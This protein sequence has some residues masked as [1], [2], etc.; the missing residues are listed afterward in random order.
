VDRPKSREEVRQLVRRKLG[1][2][3]YEACWEY[4]VVRELVDDVVNESDWQHA[5]DY[6]VEQYRWCEE[7]VKQAKM[8]RAA[9]QDKTSAIRMEPSNDRRWEALSLLLWKRAESDQGIRSFWRAVGAPLENPSEWVEKAS[10][11]RWIERL[12]KSL[13][14]GHL[15]AMLIREDTFKDEAT[16][17]EFFGHFLEAV[18]DRY[19]IDPI[20]T[21]RFL[22]QRLWPK[23]I[24][25]AKARIRYHS[26]FPC[27]DR[28]ILEID[29][30]LREEEVIQLYREIKRLYWFR[31]KTERLKARPISDK[32]YE[33]IRFVLEE[34]EG[35]TWGQ[36]LDKW[37]TRYPKGHPWHY[38]YETNMARDFH[39]LVQRLL[40]MPYKRFMRL[41]V[42]RPMPLEE[43]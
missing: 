39:R 21:E 33:L 32:G 40:G 27:L 16:A 11:P 15:H 5:L 34:G 30:C 14:E 23:Q 31:P 41:N 12:I 35:L 37:N 4:M 2:D 8:E 22:T 28:L 43:P 26:I 42:A 25:A 36:R 13:A 1:S 18:Q 38:T 20:E 29:P 9:R 7:I 19:G 3:I 6:L 10:P 24:P 17:L